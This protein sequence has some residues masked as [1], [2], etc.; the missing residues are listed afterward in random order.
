MYGTVYC[1]T[2]RQSKRRPQKSVLLWGQQASIKKFELLVVELSEH[3]YTGLGHPE[4]LR[5]R[6]GVWSRRLNQ[7]DRLCYSV[8]NDVVTVYVLSARGHYDDK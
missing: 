3:P 8:D 6:P 1:N 4:Q 5:Y 2:L 7:K